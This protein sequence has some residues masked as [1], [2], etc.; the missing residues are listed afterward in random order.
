MRQ[1]VQKETFISTG[2]KSSLFEANG[3]RLDKRVSPDSS[4]YRTVRLRCPRSRVAQRTQDGVFG[5]S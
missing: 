5:T 4:T 3:S 2:Y 1:R